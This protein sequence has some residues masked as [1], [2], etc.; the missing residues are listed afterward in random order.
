MML[1][2]RVLGPKL[3]IGLAMYSYRARLQLVPI[4]PSGAQ[5]RIQT[6]LASTPVEGILEE[7]LYKIR[8]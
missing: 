5:P 4:F 2:S 3:R 7:V 1:A 8:T 6:G